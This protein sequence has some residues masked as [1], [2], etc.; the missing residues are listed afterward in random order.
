MLDVLRS[1]FSNGLMVKEDMR[2]SRAA[3]HAGAYIGCLMNMTELHDE[4]HECI[5]HSWCVV[6]VLLLGCFDERRGD[7]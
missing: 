1:D 4:V 6:Q 5:A 2:H 3:S 7:A